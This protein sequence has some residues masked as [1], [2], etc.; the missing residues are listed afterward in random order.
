MISLHRSDVTFFP[1]WSEEL[2]P[3]SDVPD[4]GLRLES[5]ERLLR[6][7]LD[8][9]SFFLRGLAT[10]AS[11]KA[12]RPRNGFSALTAA[13]ISEVVTSSFDSGSPSLSSF[14]FDSR[15]NRWSA[16]LMSS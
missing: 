1:C 10:C 12:K 13:S 11:C 8:F 3:E 9:L 15:E 2:L 4:D 14:F 6:R 16:S 5:V 7:S